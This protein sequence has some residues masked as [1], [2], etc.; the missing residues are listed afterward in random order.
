MKSLPA[1]QNLFEFVRM[2]VKDIVEKTKYFSIIA[3]ELTDRYSNKENL[4]LYLRYL[5]ISRKIGVPVIEETFLDSNH[6]QGRPTGKA[7]GNHIL[8][9]LAITDLM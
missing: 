5:N 2:K 3:D 8:K 6:I 9:L 4:L 7:I 1:L